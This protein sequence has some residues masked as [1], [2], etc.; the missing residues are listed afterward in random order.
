MI[1]TGYFCLG[2]G[3]S[4]TPFDHSRAFRSVDVQQCYHRHHHV[5]I[6]MGPVIASLAMYATKRMV[7]RLVAGQLFRKGIPRKIRRMFSMMTQDDVVV[8]VLGDLFE[9]IMTLLVGI[10]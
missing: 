7:S 1:P 10:I 8:D 5:S 4:G 2:R 6:T 3:Q 9:E